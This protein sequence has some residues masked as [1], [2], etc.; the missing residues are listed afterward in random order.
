MDDVGVVSIDPR[1]LVVLIFLDGPR[2]VLVKQA[3]VVHE[4]VSRTGEEI[5]QEFFYLRVEHALDLG[6]VIEV[7]AFRFDMSERDAKLVHALGGSWARDRGS[8]LP[9]GARRAGFAENR[10]IPY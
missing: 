8:I 1:I 10:D 5:E 2:V 9:S 3:V 7:L 6:R 4:R